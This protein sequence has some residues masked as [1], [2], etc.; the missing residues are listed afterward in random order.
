VEFCVFMWELWWWVLLI[1]RAQLMGKLPVRNVGN[2]NKS[3]RKIK[4]QKSF[5]DLLFLFIPYHYN[6]KF[7]LIFFNLA[8]FF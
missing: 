3:L 5:N 4:N 1:E 8:L 6:S 7:G 2:C